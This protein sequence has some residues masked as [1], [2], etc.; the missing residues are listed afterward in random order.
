MEKTVVVKNLGDYHNLIKELEK[1]YNIIM[2]KN[3][4]DPWNLKN[5]FIIKIST[6]ND[7]L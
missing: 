7:K 4:S 2:S 3:L 1:I 6:K 5:P